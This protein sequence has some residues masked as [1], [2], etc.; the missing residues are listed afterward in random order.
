MEN[1]HWKIE[2]GQKDGMKIR[3]KKMKKCSSYLSIYIL[4]RYMDPKIALEQ[5]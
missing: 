3:S 2:D 4:A 5:Q 1:D